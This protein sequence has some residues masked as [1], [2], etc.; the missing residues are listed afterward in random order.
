M[1]PYRVPAARLAAAQ[2]LL[3]EAGADRYVVAGG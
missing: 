2:A 1:L 3:A